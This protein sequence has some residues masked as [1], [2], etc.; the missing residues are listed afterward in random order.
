[1]QLV[2]FVR[3]LDTG[4]LGSIRLQVIDRWWPRGQKL[5]GGS[6]LLAVSQTDC[7]Q[8]AGQSGR[9]SAEAT[10]STVLDRIH[11]LLFRPKAYAP[12]EPDQ[13]RIPKIL[14]HIFLSGDIMGHST[15]DVSFKQPFLSVCM[16]VHWGQ[17]MPE[18]A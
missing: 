14:H 16:A 12:P 8:A 18:H 10:S 2:S 4:L 9:H 1:M 7:V 17:L 11:G 3:Q 5:Q 6:G 15:R 13:E